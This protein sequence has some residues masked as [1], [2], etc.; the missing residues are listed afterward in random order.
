MTDDS[1]GRTARSGDGAHPSL[2]ELSAHLDGHAAGAGA[3]SLAEHLDGC[4]D[5]AALLG[6]LTLAR[7]ALEQAVLTPADPP[8]PAHA[9]ARAA[10]VAAALEATGRAA[11]PPAAAPRDEA[12]SPLLRLQRRERRMRLVGV[13]AAV[14]LVA[15]VGSGLGL[16]VHGTGLGSSGSAPT[17]AGTTTSAPGQGLASRA[18]SGGS[19]LDHG[20]VGVPRPSLAIVVSA[21][22]CTALRAQSGAGTRVVTSRTLAGS[23]SGCLDV[24]AVGVSLGQTDRIL[25]TTPAPGGARRLVIGLV[26]AVPPGLAAHQLVVVQGSDALGRATVLSA[27]RLRVTGLTARST[28]LLEAALA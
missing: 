23:P 9:R 7:T 1:D 5:C 3:A 26:K 11:A 14:A 17:A 8:S 15:A 16:L 22:G 10:A 2:E 18:G 19:Q 4:D 28:Q 12:P 25:S 27:K 21:G 20:P 24:R 6:R 13:A